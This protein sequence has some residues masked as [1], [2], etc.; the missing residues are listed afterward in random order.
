MVPRRQEGCKQELGGAGAASATD[1]FPAQGSKPFSSAPVLNYLPIAQDSFPSWLLSA[2]TRRKLLGLSQNI[3]LSGSSSGSI[4][5]GRGQQPPTGSAANGRIVGMAPAALPVKG[6][7]IFTS[8][9][10]S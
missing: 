7:T 1:N 9:A 3:V 4:R 5:R 6:Q 8:A 2:S 10:Y